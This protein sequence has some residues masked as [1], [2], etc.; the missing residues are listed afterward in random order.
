MYI[1]ELIHSNFA[2]F[3]LNLLDFSPIMPAFSFLLYSSYYSNNFAGIIDWSLT[4][5]II[6]H[7]YLLKHVYGIIFFFRLVSPPIFTTHPSSQ[8]AQI[9]ENAT[10]SCYAIGYK[11]KYHWKMKSG[12]LPSKVIGKNTNTLVIPGV[13]LSDNNIYTCVASNIK[14]IVSS[15][16]AELIVKGTRERFQIMQWL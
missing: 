2:R 8:S 13:T 10:F 1:K 6:I 5:I 4:T 15:N 11:V 7:Q 14:G 3:C 12:S 16:P 9:A